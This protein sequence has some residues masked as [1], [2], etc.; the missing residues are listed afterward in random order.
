[1]AP[2]PPLNRKKHASPKVLDNNGQ[3]PVGQLMMSN[4]YKSRC[5]LNFDQSKAQTGS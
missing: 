3:K 2:V 1:M 4:T 5:H